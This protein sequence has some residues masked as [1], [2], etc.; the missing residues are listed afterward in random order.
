MSP[1]SS[2]SRF[3]QVVDCAIDISSATTF[4]LAAFA[5]GIRI[6]RLQFEH[7]GKI[8]LRFRWFVCRAV[9]FAAIAVML[10]RFLDSP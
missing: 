1:H 7:I 5:K 8:S 2:S 6:L 4:S 3:G 10:C 9:G